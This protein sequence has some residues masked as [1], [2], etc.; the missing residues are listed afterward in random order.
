[1]AKGRFISKDISLDEK[2]NSLS[3]DTVRLLW[4]WLIPHLDCEGRTYGDAQTVRSIVFP[5]R[6]MDVR[7]I[8]KYLVEL[9][10]SGLILRY[11]NVDGP[12]NKAYKAYLYCPNFEKHQVGLNKSREAQSRIPPFTQ[13]LLRSSS[14]ITPAEVEA[15]VKVKVKVKVEDKDTTTTAGKKN[16]ENIFT[17]YEGNI[18]MLTP[19]ISDELKAIEQKYSLEWFKAAVKEACESQVRNLKY[20]QKI[21]ERWERDGFKSPMKK[22]DQKYGINQKTFKSIP[23]NRPAGAFS[24]LKDV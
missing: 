5:R 19:I 14:G 13:E 21:L 23:G 8:E 15:E 11:P 1:M 17:I 12:Q 9:E 6:T 16:T 4:T 3:S 7:T 20:V 22:E 2:V 10:Q 24:D 18:G